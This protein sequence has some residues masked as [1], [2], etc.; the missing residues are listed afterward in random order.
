MRLH[1]PSSVPTVIS[2]IISALRLMLIHWIH[3]HTLKFRRCY[4]SRDSVSLM[5]FDVVQGYRS[6]GPGKWNLHCGGMWVDDIGLNRK[7][8]VAYYGPDLYQPDVKIRA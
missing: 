3:G 1:L 8:K 2:S 4:C 6:E 5:L 7:L